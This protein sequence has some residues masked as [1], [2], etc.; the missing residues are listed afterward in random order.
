MNIEATTLFYPPC[1]C[2]FLYQ[3]LISFRSASAKF[4]ITIFS[5]HS[6]HYISAMFVLT[7]RDSTSTAHKQKWTDSTWQK[8]LILFPVEITSIQCECYIHP[9]FFSG[10]NWVSY[11]VFVASVYR[12]LYVP[13]MLDREE[14]ARNDREKRRKGRERKREREKEWE[15]DRTGEKKRESERMREIER[16]WERMREIKREAET[17][18]SITTIW[19]R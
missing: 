19:M 6:L 5:T 17:N 10:W 2:D 16:E 11:L 18:H 7:I 8:N 14:L 13:F 9:Y 4:I 3:W 1:V 15:R 12:M